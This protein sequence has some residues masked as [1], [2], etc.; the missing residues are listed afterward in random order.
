M[1]QTSRVVEWLMGHADIYSWSWSSCFSLL[2]IMWQLPEWLNDFWTM[3]TFTLDH[4]HH[5]HVF[6]EKKNLLILERT[7]TWSHSSEDKAVETG[8]PN[9]LLVLAVWPRSIISQ[10]DQKRFTF[11]LGKPNITRKW[12]EL[13]FAFPFIIIRISAFSVSDLLPLI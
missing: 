5:H 13:F 11:E 6:D 9:K 8:R 12:A 2:S 1:W 7:W 4:H 3:L 10:E